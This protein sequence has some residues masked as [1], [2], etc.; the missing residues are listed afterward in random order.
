MKFSLLTY[1]VEC[2]TKVGRSAIVRAESHYDALVA[3]AKLFNCNIKD[4]TAYLA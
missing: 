3:G 4:I 1:R 2:D